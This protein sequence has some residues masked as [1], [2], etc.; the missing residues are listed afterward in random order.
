MAAKELLVKLQEVEEQ[1][2]QLKAH[3]EGLLQEWE[4]KKRGPRKVLK[5]LNPIMVNVGCLARTVRG[6]RISSRKPAGARQ[7]DFRHP[8]ARPAI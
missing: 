3:Q 8:A 1:E 7:G 6:R 5:S 4:L 2:Q